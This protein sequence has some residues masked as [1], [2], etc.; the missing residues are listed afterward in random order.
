MRDKLEFVIALKD[1]N[2]SS[3]LGKATKGIDSLRDRANSLGST[4]SRL[5]AMKLAIGGLAAGAT[6]HYANEVRKIADE[7]VNLHA[8]IKLVTE[9]EQEPSMVREQLYQ[10]SQNTGSSYASN[11]DSYAKLARSVKDLGGDA[12]DTLQIV[13][14]VNKSLTI[15]GSSTEMAAAFMQQFAQALG[16]GVLQGDEFRSM[17]ENNGYFAAKLAEVLKTDIAGL[18]AMAT[19]G[20]LTADV[21]RTAFPKMAADTNKDFGQIPPTVDRAMV[22][23]QNSFKRLVSDSNEASGGTGKIATSVINL[24]TTIDNNRGRIISLFSVIIDMAAGATDKVAKLATAVGNIVQS[25][26]GWDAVFKGDLSFFEFATMN[27][28]ELDEWLK[29]NKRSLEDVG[30]AS[31]AAHQDVAAGAKAGAEAMKKVTGDALKEM[32]K[33]YQNYAKEI[34][35]LQGDLGDHQRS[36]EEELREMRRSGM[37]DLGAWRD[38]R[39]EAAEFTQK[40]REAA[41]AAKKLFAAGNIEAGRETYKVAAEYADKAMAAYKDLNEEVKRGDQVVI[42]QGTALRTAMAGVREAGELKATIMQEQTAA[43]QDAQKALNEQAGGQLDQSLEATRGKVL[44]LGAAA[45]EAKGKVQELLTIEPPADGDWG[46]VWAS[47]ESGSEQA[48][49]SVTSTWDGVWDRFLAS[50]SEDIATLEKQLRELAKDR[51]TKLYVEKIEKNR[52]GGMVGAY[53]NGGQVWPFARGGRLPGYGGGDRV[54]ALL[55]PGE[56]VIRKEAVSRYGTAFLHALNDMRLSDLGTVRA[57]LGGF[58]ADFNNATVQRFQQGGLASHAP[59]ETVNLNLTLPGGSGP[60]PMKIGKKE[61]DQL[62]REQ[63]RAYQRRSTNNWW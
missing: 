56:F 55:E 11:A 3:G 5:S 41:E 32:K 8:R 17:L 52:L 10:M 30:K 6:A 14:L 54:R 13:E 51:H 7:Y 35:Q 47:M 49:K 15:N 12:K 2:F 20:E 61:L 42:S 26:S 16:S 21:L 23:L 37:S 39:N 63:A 59:T 50:G 9:S 36:A 45:D 18:R 38:R 44:E 46:K 22:M 19:A 60:I 4:L 25:G 57:R 40:A 48:G 62:K 43:L 28:K 27:A 33:Q 34:K 58:I 29:K 53:R 24:A 31:G 1:T